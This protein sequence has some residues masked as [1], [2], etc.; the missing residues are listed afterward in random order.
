MLSW[1][2]DYLSAADATKHRGSGKEEKAE[3]ACNAAV[4]TT[5]A[6]A[7]ELQNAIFAPASTKVQSTNVSLKAA[8]RRRNCA[9]TTWRNVHQCAAEGCGNKAE[10]CEH[11]EAKCANC[12]GA[13]VATSRKCPEKFPSRQKRASDTQ[14]MR[15]SPP[16]M[17]FQTNEGTQASMESQ[18]ET[19]AA[20][21]D[22][23]QNRPPHT[24]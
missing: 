18:E 10:P 1:Q 21:L 17:D 4:M 19:D 9:S 24:I 5:L 6:N 14:N 13:H 15:S 20:Q 3:C 11:H 8:A 22:V 23:R 7:R 12:G 2:K 16:L